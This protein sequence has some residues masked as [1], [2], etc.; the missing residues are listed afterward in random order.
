M[1][2]DHYTDLRFTEDYE[3]FLFYSEGPKGKLKKLVVY[4]SLKNLPGGYNLGFGTLK[5]N[6]SG[7]DYLDGTEI[8]DNGDR[9][10][11][12]ATVALT[13]FIFIENYPDKRIY[14]TGSDKIRT[15]LYQMAINHAY[16]QLSE[17][18]IIY[19]DLAESPNSYDLQLFENGKNYAGF[20]VEKRV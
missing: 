12:L 8:S 10:K 11:V 13:A 18:F 9:N 6:K 19:G 14:L 2:Y 1:N 3:L 17:M 5:I 15:R 16:E 4:T 20:L 7:Q